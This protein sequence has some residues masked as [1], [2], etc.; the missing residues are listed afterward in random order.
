MN[1]SDFTTKTSTIEQLSLFVD[2][3]VF[4]EA[5]NW[6]WFWEILKFQVTYSNQS[7]LLGAFRRSSE[8]LD[9]FEL[10]RKAPRSC[11]WCSSDSLSLSLSLSL[12]KRT[13]PRSPWK[14][15]I[16]N[17]CYP[18]YRFLTKSWNDNILVLE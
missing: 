10:W 14:C 6:Q 7:Q 2:L 16:H 17:T 11:D 4:K 5:H 8:T 15:H 18:V 3:K 12:S 9:V 1:H 13:Y